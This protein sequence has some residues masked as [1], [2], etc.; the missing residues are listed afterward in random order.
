M[1][2]EQQVDTYPSMTVAK[3]HGTDRDEKIEPLKLGKRLK[4]IRMAHGLTLEEASKR[5][6]LA[7][8][9]LSKIENEQISP[10]VPGD[11]KAGWWARNRYSSAV[12][13]TKADKSNG[14]Q[15]YHP[16]G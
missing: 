15:R 4:E 16:P 12:C 1:S 11:A 8:S 13:T 2:D 7:R 10:H 9:T 14:S 6:G 3:E 5:T